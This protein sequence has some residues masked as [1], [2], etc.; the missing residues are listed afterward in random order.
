MPCLPMIEIKRL[1]QSE[2]RRVEICIEMGLLKLIDLRGED[3][4]LCTVSEM[5]TGYED[6]LDDITY[7][8]IGASENVLEI[9]VKGTLCV[10]EE[11]YQYAHQSFDEDDSSRG[12]CGGN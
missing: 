12:E 6:G 8:V 10:S 2:N 9:C 1:Q 4:F 7:Q 3:D 11:Y 5:I